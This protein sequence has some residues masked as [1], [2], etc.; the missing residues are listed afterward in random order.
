MYRYQSNMS[1]IGQNELKLDLLRKTFLLAPSWLKLLL[2]CA[3]LQYDYYF[4][5]SVLVRLECKLKENTCV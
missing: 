1:N 2:Y 3:S 4:K 5:L